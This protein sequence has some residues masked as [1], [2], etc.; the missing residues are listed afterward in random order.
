VWPIH[1]SEILCRAQKSVL[2]GV[3]NATGSHEGPKTWN[4]NKSYKKNLI[5]SAKKFTFSMELEVF[6]TIIQQTYSKLVISFMNRKSSCGYATHFFFSISA[7]FFHSLIFF[8]FQ[9]FV[10]MKC[11]FVFAISNDIRHTMKNVCLTYISKYR[12]I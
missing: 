5:F 7:N 10:I 1:R 9:N 8:S 12:S 3:W 11:K 4:F 6:F 2:Y